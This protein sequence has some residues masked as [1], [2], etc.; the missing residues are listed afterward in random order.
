[1]QTELDRTVSAAFC[2]VIEQLAFMFA[3]PAAK[4]ELPAP[5]GPWVAVGMKFA[6]ALEGR[7]R[8]AVPMSICADLAENILGADLDCEQAEAKA[9]DALKEVLNVT[10]G[11]ILT[12]LAGLEPVFALTIPEVTPLDPVAWQGMFGQP[13]VQALLVD[14]YPVLLHF[15]MKKAAT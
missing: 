5:D 6:G 14:E 15:E 13:D 12:D 9:M 2:R 7:L 4:D 10:C 8:L 3:E 1:M 11:N